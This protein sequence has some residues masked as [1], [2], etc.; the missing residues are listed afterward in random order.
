MADGND[1]IVTEARERW[2]RADSAE[3]AQRESILEAKEFRAG[4]QWD[5]AIKTQRE[6]GNSI[7]G[8]AQQPARPCLTI[9]RISQPVRQAS[10]A[11]KQANI[12]IDV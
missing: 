3:K 10:N 2:I 5:P 4:K 8:Q 6:G 9:D 7:G 1:P 12:S 11:V